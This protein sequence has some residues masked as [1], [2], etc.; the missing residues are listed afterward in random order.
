MKENR[1]IITGQKKKNMSHK[2]FNASEIYYIINELIIFQFD[3]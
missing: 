3:A 1:K 2:E